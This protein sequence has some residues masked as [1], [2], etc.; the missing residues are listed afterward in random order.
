MF[1]DVPCSGV[2]ST[3]YTNMA[4]DYLCLFAHSSSSPKKDYMKE[5]SIILLTN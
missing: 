5:L 1:R 3:A 2:L 4:G